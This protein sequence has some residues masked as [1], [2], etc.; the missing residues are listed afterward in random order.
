MDITET[1]TPEQIDKWQE[2]FKKYQHP[3]KTKTVQDRGIEI[4]NS[5]NVEITDSVL[6]PEPGLFKNHIGFRVLPDGVEYFFGFH[7][8]IT[9]KRDN[10]YGNYILYVKE[11]NL[12]VRFIEHSVREWTQ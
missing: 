11:K 1:L 5:A 3:S 6:D 12:A 10:R 8:S 4:Q 2:E 7:G 9:T